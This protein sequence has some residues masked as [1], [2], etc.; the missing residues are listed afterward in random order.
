MSQIVRWSLVALG[1][2]GVFVVALAVIVVGVFRFGVLPLDDGRRLADGCVEVVTEQW[3]PVTIGSYLISLRNGGY[4]LFDTGMDTEAN[5]TLSALR[6]QGAGARDVLSIFVTHAHPDHVGGMEAFPD[7]EVYASEAA[8]GTI[9]RRYSREA[10]G[11]ADGDQVTVSGT[12]VEM[13]ALPGHTRGSAAYL[14]CGVLF[15]GDS[16]ASIYDGSVLPNR[17]LSRDPQGTEESLAVLVQK[18]QSRSEAVRHIA[19]GHQG[20]VD[21]LGPLI[22]WASYRRPR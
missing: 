14:A 5:A 4:A 19:F 12:E 8:A 3:G 15:L 13:F 9:R 11:L 22:E 17:Y 20:P 16:A 7:A 6:R 10:K 21:S 2:A 18:L 1:V